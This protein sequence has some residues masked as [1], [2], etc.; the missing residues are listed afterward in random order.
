LE[1][2]SKVSPRR[3]TG[4]Q[5]ETLVK[6]L[7]DEPKTIKVISAMLDLE[8][9]DFADDFAS[10]MRQA[11]WKVLVNKVNLSNEYCVQIAELDG[12]TSPLPTDLAMP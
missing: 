4:A 6:F 3:L 5:K 12:K 9:S 2:E 11:G 8:G 10:A 7:S 1:I